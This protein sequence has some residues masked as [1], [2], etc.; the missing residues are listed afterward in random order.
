MG[1]LQISCFLTEGLFLGT[2]INL[3][4]IFPKVPGCTF[5]P[6]LSKIIT[7]AAAPLVLTPFVRNQAGLLIII[8]TTIII[9]IIT[10]NYYDDYY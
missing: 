9:I 3:L 1:S 8:T 2:P 7:V 6:N 4:L 10:T 5:F